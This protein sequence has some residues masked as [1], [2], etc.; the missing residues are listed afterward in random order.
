MQ[1]NID[2]LMLKNPETAS[3]ICLNDP[4]C[5]IFGKEY[6]GQVRRLSFGACLTLPFQ[7]CLTIKLNGINLASS[8]GT[9]LNVEDKVV[10]MESELAIVKNQMQTFLAYCF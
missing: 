6:P 8:S 4:V 10:K 3:D 2:D 9:S 5:V 1:E 7:Q